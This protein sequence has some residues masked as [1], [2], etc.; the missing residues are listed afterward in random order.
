MR[1]FW[2]HDELRGSKPAN[3]GFRRA[4]RPRCGRPSVAGP[5]TA[6]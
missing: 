5:C 6:D 4:R 2:S 1:A 3:W